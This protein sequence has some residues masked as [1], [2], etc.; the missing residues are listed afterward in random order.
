MDENV[1]NLET[2]KFLKGWGSLRSVRSSRLCA[3]R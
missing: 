2:R 3:M 1:L